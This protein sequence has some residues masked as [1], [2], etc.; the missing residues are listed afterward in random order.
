MADHPLPE[1]TRL[2]LSDL[3]LRIKTMKVNLGS[4]IE[5]VLTRALDPPSAINIRRAV[6][7]LVEVC[8][9]SILRFVV[10]LITLHLGSCTHPD[11][12][13]YPVGSSAQQAPDR[14]PPWKIPAYRHYLR[15]FRPSSYGRR[16][17]V[18]QVSVPCSLWFGRCRRP[19]E[20]PIQ[21]QEFGF[22]DNTQ[23]FRWLEESFCPRYR[24]SQIV[25]PQK[26]FKSPGKPAP[27]PLEDDYVTPSRIS[28]Q[29]KNFDNSF[30]GTSSTRLSSM[31]RRS[32]YGNSAGRPIQVKE[33]NQ[34]DKTTL[35][36][37]LGEKQNPFHAGA[38]RARQ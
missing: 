34:A 35:Q 31:S 9:P 28:K 14:C 20:R 21:D 24:I 26:L 5:D 25:L 11:R 10:V 8:R 2:S 19:C 23:C 30:L 22:L 15:L 32:T 37:T 18:F 3:A 29:W 6:S 12:G 33:K 7:A 4:T 16:R 38:T 17:P 27:Q 13:Y 36:N 1:M